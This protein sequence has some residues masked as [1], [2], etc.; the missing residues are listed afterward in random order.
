MQISK[1]AKAVESC[2][3]WENYVRIG[4]N[5]NTHVQSWNSRKREKKDICINNRAVHIQTDT[6]QSWEITYTTEPSLLILFK[7]P[8][9]ESLLGCLTRE[10]ASWWEI[11]T[12]WLRWTP[13]LRFLPPSANH[14]KH[15][16]KTNENEQKDQIE[17]RKE[18][19]NSKNH[20]E[21][22]RK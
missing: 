20:T 8:S 1:H 6:P 5:R 22:N 4:K 12:S 14:T 3:Y 18:Y 16:I 9:V 21:Q 19:V 11:G 15:S 10:A 13:Q 7:L 17:R 2:S